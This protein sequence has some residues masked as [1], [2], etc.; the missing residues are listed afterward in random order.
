M[1]MYV[2]VIRRLMGAGADPSSVSVLK[3]RTVNYGAVRV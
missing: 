3:E 1:A 2:P